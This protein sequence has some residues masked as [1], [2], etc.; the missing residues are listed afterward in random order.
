[1]SRSALLEIKQELRL[2]NQHATQIKDPS[3]TNDY[4]QLES[5]EQSMDESSEGPEVIVDEQGRFK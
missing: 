4:S 3:V 5:N 1:M 2:Q